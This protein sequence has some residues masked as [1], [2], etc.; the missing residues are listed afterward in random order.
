MHEYQFISPSLDG[1]LHHSTI[2]Y[3]GIHR[4][5]AILKI[6][7]GPAQRGRKKESDTASTSLSEHERKII[8]QY[9]QD[10]YALFMKKLSAYIVDAEPRS[11]DSVTLPAL[12]QE[13]IK[14]KKLL[15]KTIQ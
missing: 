5:V 15:E 14:M 2:V 7:D 10:I 6:L 4:P 9:F 8:E 1:I 13:M 12:L 3:E 11:D